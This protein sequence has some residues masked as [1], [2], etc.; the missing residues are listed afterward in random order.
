VSD[1]RIG[2]VGSRP[3]IFDPVPEVPAPPKQE[4]LSFSKLIKDVA[5]DAVEA[6]QDAARAIED[7]AAGK[8]DDVHDV[9]LAAGKANLAISLLVQIRN[10]VLDA[11]QELSR[12][13]M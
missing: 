11:Y 10:G 1:I 8:I 5:S 6:E 13:S 3:R 9:V 7:F 2:P 4:G 12:I